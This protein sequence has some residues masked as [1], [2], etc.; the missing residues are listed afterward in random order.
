VKKLII[1]FFIVKC[2]NV[3]AQ[4]RFK[5][6]YKLGITF[7]GLTTN[8]TSGRVKSHSKGGYE[9]GIWQ[10][11]KMSKSWAVQAELYYVVKGAGGFHADRPP[12]PGE[13]LLGLS[14]IE[15]PILFQY[16]K[17]KFNFEF[18]PGLGV[19]LSQFEILNG[20]LYPDMTDVYP[21]TKNELSGNVGIGYSLNEK[22]YLGFR[23]NQ[24]LLPV[25]RQLPDVSAQV[26]NRVFGIIVA[27][28]LTFRK[29]KV[30]EG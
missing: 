5:D 21:F 15:M 27:R 20:A 24:S 22:W 12:I 16:R 2:V 6:R 19:L 26:Y 29:S 23:Y 28:S 13:Y 30:K 8:V 11:L 3:S 7:G 4:S 25:R 9:I 10:R 14:Y 17:K 1:I 18:G